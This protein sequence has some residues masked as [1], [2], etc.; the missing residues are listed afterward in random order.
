[1]EV[2]ISY[3][4]SYFHNSHCKYAA[5]PTAEENKSGL[6]S[7]ARHSNVNFLYTIKRVI[8][9]PILEGILGLHSHFLVS[10]S[11]G[12]NNVLRR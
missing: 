2:Y 9:K 5:V 10:L 3:F 6:S 8:V 1:M 7:T 11:L 4:K 12:A